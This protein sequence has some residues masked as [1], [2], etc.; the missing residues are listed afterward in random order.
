MDDET[1]LLD[2]SVLN[3][4]FQARY[5]TF[6]L[7]I[8]LE[9]T[10]VLFATKAD[11]FYRQLKQLDVKEFVMREKNV[12]WSRKIFNRCPNLETI[13]NVPVT[14]GNLKRD[15]ISVQLLSLIKSVSSV[16]V[17]FHYRYSPLTM[18]PTIGMV[19]L[20]RLDISARLVPSGE[21]SFD[22]V[23]TE[24]LRVTSLTCDKLNLMDV[25]Q[26]NL[27]NILH[28]K[29]TNVVIDE[30]IEKLLKFKNLSELT[31]QMNCP[32]NTDE[33]LPLVNFVSDVLHVGAFSLQLLRSLNEED[34][35]KICD[36]KTLLKMCVTQLHLH[37]L[38]AECVPEIF[39]FSKLRYL[40]LFN[41]NVSTDIFLKS[42]PN[43]C[44]LEAKCAITIN[45]PDGESVLG[46]VS[47]FDT[48]NKRTTPTGPE[49]FD[50]SCHVLLYLDN[51]N[52]HLYDE[53]EVN[54]FI[55]F[56][57]PDGFILC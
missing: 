38:S 54:I 27:V 11:T 46:F 40:Y 28:L 8:R 9:P 53:F 13:E 51:Q 22:L 16:G 36:H 39:Q 19:N 21:P 2:G 6:D 1:I 15:M 12:S 30:L 56:S 29:F 10:S 20:S 18:L 25:C 26:P 57:H 14:T 32:K 43:L 41:V 45:S 31:V 52:N 49:N 4:L 35:A 55:F 3:C 34:F 37:N 33:L 50:V 48:K 42:L 7:C 44:H 17:E 47:I 24:K 23:P 5:M